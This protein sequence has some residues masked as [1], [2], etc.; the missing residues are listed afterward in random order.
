MLAPS[1]LL[2]VVLQE[3]EA[4]PREPVLRVSPQ[5]QP[6]PALVLQEPTA[7]LAR[8]VLQPRVQQVSLPPGPRV[9][10]PLASPQLEH[11]RAQG[12]RPQGWEP[13]LLA[14][15]GPPWQPLLLRRVPL[16]RRIPPRQ[17]PA[18]GA[19]LSPR[20]LQG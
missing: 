8:Q 18:D 7:Q 9:R 3:Q 1:E 5:A 19:S 17:R 2:A 20:C 16:R 13:E 10:V 14:G 4:W 15:A 6:E 11:A 12:E